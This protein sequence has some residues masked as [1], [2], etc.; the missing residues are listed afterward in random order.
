MVHNPVSFRDWSKPFLGHLHTRNCPRPGYSFS[1]T[2]SCD[3]FRHP[4]RISLAQRSLRAAV[5]HQ[6]LRSCTRPSL[7]TFAFPNTPSLI[8]S[9]DGLELT[10][11]KTR[12]DHAIDHLKLADDFE[13]TTLDWS[14]IIIKSPAGDF[15]I[16]Y[17]THSFLII[18]PETGDFGSATFEVPCKSQVS[19]QANRT[20][21]LECLTQWQ[22]IARVSPISQRFNKFS[23]GNSPLLRLRDAVRATILS[24]NGDVSRSTKIQLMPS[25]HAEKGYICAENKP[26]LA[27]ALERYLLA[28]YPAVCLAQGNGDRHYVLKDPT[29]MIFPVGEMDPPAIMRGLADIDLS[30]YKNPLL[31]AGRDL[32]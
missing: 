15:R 4:A 14:G 30:P 28:P 7:L 20:V 25:T 10:S 18:T 9:L 29:C 27:T 16:C 12:L 6:A 13:P 32:R 5:A 31:K 2:S 23:W 26:I 19:P 11:L 1:Q 24:L 21:A 17:R 3:T 22:A 8:T